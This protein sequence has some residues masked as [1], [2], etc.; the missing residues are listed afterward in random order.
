MTSA[1]FA[2][3]YRIRRTLS[4][5]GARSQAVQDVA[6]GRMVMVHYLDVGTVAEREWLLNRVHG[7]DEESER[8]IIEIVDVDGVPGVVTQVLPPFDDLPA[9]LDNP[10]AHAIPAHHAPVVPPVIPVPSPSV[11]APPALKV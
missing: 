2:E 7:L 3:K 5:S 11:V 9:W 4:T 1:E 10:H 8:K 6:H